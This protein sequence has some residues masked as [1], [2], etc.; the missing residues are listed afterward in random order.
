MIRSR[1]FL[2]S[3]IR[4]QYRTFGMSRSHLIEDRLQQSGN[5]KFGTNFEMKRGVKS[6]SKKA[7]KLGPTDNFEKEARIRES[8]AAWSMP[9]KGE[10]DEETIQKTRRVQRFESPVNF[11]IPPVQLQFETRPE[12]VFNLS[13]MLWAPPAGVFQ[14]LPFHVYRTVKGQRLPVYTEYMARKSQIY[15]QIRRFR[16]DLTPLKRE[17]SIVCNGKEITEHKGYLEVNG[18]FQIELMYWLTSL[19]F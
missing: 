12:L 6:T 11:W 19:G 18:D 14:E 13:A 7:P 8:F 9:K 17:M 16:G 5:L 15:T 1:Y 4:S 10:V 2:G 3:M